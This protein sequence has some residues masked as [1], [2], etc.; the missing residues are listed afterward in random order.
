[1][2]RD[3]KKTI[4]DVVQKYGRWSNVN[5]CGVMW[6]NLMWC[7]CFVC[8]TD[9]FCIPQDTE[10]K[11]IEDN[12]AQPS[13]QPSQKSS[14]QGECLANSCKFSFDAAK[15]DKHNNTASACVGLKNSKLMCDVG[16]DRYGLTSSGTSKRCWT[17]RKNIVIRQD[18]IIW[19]FQTFHVSRLLYITLISYYTTLHNIYLWH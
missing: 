2:W 4:R 14:Y 18:C 1:M 8:D 10:K 19:Q 16:S 15:G 6:W 13:A 17:Y 5:V 3:V 12:A 7:W 11:S 9:T